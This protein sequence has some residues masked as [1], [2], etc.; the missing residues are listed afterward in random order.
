LF[1]IF[2][3]FEENY[4]WVYYTKKQKNKKPAFVAKFIVKS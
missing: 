3:I 1:A 4:H 2:F